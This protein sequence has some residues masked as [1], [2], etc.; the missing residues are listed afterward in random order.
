M[1]S[2]KF[3]AGMFCVTVSFYVATHG[4]AIANDPAQPATDTPPDA[5]FTIAVS[6]SATASH[7]PDKVIA[8]TI[9]GEDYPIRPHGHEASLRRT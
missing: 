1:V 4:M 2:S 8:N 6:S 7:A 9:E 3:Q 5:A